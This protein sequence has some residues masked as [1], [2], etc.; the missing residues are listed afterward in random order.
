[1]KYQ[2]YALPASKYRSAKSLEFNGTTDWMA[3]LIGLGADSFVIHR[4]D[5]VTVSTWVKSTKDDC[6]EQQTIMTRWFPHQSLQINEGGWRIYSFDMAGGGNP[7]VTRSMVFHVCTH[8][9][10]G[11]WIYSQ[12]SFPLNTWVHVTL[13]YDGSGTVAGL[14]MY[15]DGVLQ[16][17]YTIYNTWTTEAINSN[18]Y[19]HL[20][21]GCQYTAWHPLGAQPD[22]PPVLHYWFEG[23]MDETSVRRY[24]LDATEVLELYHQGRPQNPMHV[25]Q[26]AGKS[27][28]THWRMGEKKDGAQILDNGVC[29]GRYPIT[30]SPLGYRNALWNNFATN[31]VSEDTPP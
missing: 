21:W 29:Y 8:F 15:W 28:Q 24:E 27:C 22:W 13:T 5:A 4:S 26:P 3:V 9:L 16:S 25:G 17:T 6:S 11:L 30:G 23:L 14:K 7:L 31:R 19:S 20:L 1:M 18:A 2:Q 10:E 12:A